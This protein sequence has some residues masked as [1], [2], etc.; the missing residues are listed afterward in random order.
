MKTP[1][2]QTKNRI[3]K[4]LR[5][6][7]NT[8]RWYLAPSVLGVLLF[9]V[10]PFL[11]VIYYSMVDNPI[12]NNFVFLENFGRILKNRAFKRAVTNTFSFSMIAVPAAVILSLLM[13]IMLEVKIPFR[14]QFRTFFL[15]PLMVPVASIV[16]IWQV[17][18]HHNGVVNE[19]LANFGVDKIILK[20]YI[21]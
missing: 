1:N 21:V 8:T 18:F 17:L 20:V 3:G 15:S 13:A 7:R 5:K 12:S 14:S 10:I 19:F 9:F 2:V 16:L 11:V 6:A 4:R